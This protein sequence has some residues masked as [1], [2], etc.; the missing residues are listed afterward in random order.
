MVVPEERQAREIALTYKERQ[1]EAKPVARR[2][3]TLEEFRNRLEAGQVKSLNLILKADVHGSVEALRDAIAKVVSDRVKLNILHWGVGSISESD[4]LLAE[5]S[6]AVVMGF[7]VSLTQEAQELARREAVD[8][9]LYRV[10]YEA[11]EDVRS[12]IAGLLGPK[13]VEQVLGRAKVLQVFQVSKAGKVAGCQV[14]KGKLLRNSLGRVWRGQTKIFEG[15][16]ISLKRF[17][18]DVREVPEGVQC[19]LALAGFDDYQPNDFIESIAVQEV[20][21]TL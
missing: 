5:A 7:N 12:A 20:A 14:V 18:D 11:V 9:R 3:L 15:K 16:I 10:I 21:Q 6:D 4:I 8:V 17:K 1:R 13:Q 19:G 2:V